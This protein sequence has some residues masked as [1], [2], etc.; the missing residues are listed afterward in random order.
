M[1]GKGKKTT[2]VS[3][4]VDS[5]EDTLIA[6]YTTNKATKSK[7]ADQLGVTE[8]TVSNRITNLRNRLDDPDIV[9]WNGQEYRVGNGYPSKVEELLDDEEQEP[10]NDREEYI[11]KELPARTDELAEE[12]GI[13]EIAVE[14]HIDS[15][16]EKGYHIEFDERTEAWH[17]EQ[18]PHLRSSEAIGTR[19]RAANE[20]WE[21]KHDELVQDFRAL[22]T[23]SVELEHNHGNQDVVSH[24][25][26]LHM[27]DRI[28]NGDGE[29]IYNTEIGQDVIRYITH[30]QLELYELQNQMIEFDT[31]HELWGGDFVTNEGIYQGQFE[32]LDAWLDEQHD[33][34]FE[35]LLERLK[36]ISKKAKTVNVVCKTGN[37]G[38]QRASGKS[39]Q[40]N[41]DLILYK[42]IRNTVSQLQEHAD[43][44]TN[45]NF[46][47]GSSRPYK[48]FEIRNKFNG[49]LLHGDDRKAGYRTSSEQSDWAKTALNTDF[50]FAYAG[51]IHRNI[52]FSV[53]DRQVIVTGS[54]KPSGEFARKISALPN[55]DIGTLH[56]VSDDGITFR[57]DIDFRDFESFDGGQ[58]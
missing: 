6:I 45:V 53:E 25:T 16:S 49:L 48:Q 33:A 13:S 24:I 46:Q 20:W 3:D 26:D 5:L 29:E 35:P 8:G 38:E 21:K 11:L 27:G 44:L 50:D 19:T 57:Y 39:R 22:Q 28:H 54:P 18:S 58:S 40:A 52:D 30:K 51:H 17:S 56:G 55:Y 23:P 12:F 37:H 31:W 1:S 9:V 47:I 43:I 10:L 34:L 7:I 4:L 2:E 15:I 42:H 36:A 14:G 41:S 32:D